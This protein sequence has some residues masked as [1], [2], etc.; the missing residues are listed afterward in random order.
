MS[1]LKL[2][3]LV[4]NNLKLNWVGTINGWKLT[5]SQLM[6]MFEERMKQP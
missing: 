2:L 1:L 3:Y 4:Q 6:I 5:M